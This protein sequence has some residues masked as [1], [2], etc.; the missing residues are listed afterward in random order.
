MNYNASSKPRRVMEPLPVRTVT[1]RIRPDVLCGAVMDALTTSVERVGGE[2]TK[3]QGGHLRAVLPGKKMRAWMPGEW[4]R[5][6]IDENNVDNAGDNVTPQTSPRC[7]QN[8]DAS[9]VASG[10][11][12]MLSLSPILGGTPR[13]SKRKGP[14]YDILPPYIVD[15]QLVTKKVGKE[16]QRMVLIRIYRVQ[17]V[18]RAA[19]MGGEEENNDE[20]AYDV[21][22]PLD[23][24]GGN[25]LHDEQFNHGSVNHQNNPAVAPIDPL[26][27][28]KRSLKALQEASALVQRI[29]AVGGSGFAIDPPPLPMLHSD[30]GDTASVTSRTS[31][32]SYLKSFADTITSPIRYFGGSNNAVSPMK[33]SSLSPC[34]TVMELMSTE[35]LRK[36]ISSPSVGTTS[37]SALAAAK[38]K[39]HGIFP[40]LSMEDAPYV[41]SSWIF[42]RDCIEELDRRCLAYSTLGIYPIFQF[43]ALP[44]LDVHFIA[45]IKAFCRESMIVS[46][47]KTA[48]ELEIY[49]REFEVSCGNVEQL[50]RP[51]F[52]RYKLAP[53]QLPT[54]VPL[55]A[56]PLDFR[57]PEEISP[58]WGPEVMAAL[59][60]ISNDLVIQSTD[61]NDQQAHHRKK[62]S[63]DQTQNPLSSFERSEK[64]ISIVVAAFQQ[65]NDVEQGARLGRKNMQVMDR[66]AKMQAHKRNSIAKIRGSYGT[67]LLATRAADEFHSLRQKS[68]N[69]GSLTDVINAVPDEVPLLTCNVLV[70][71]AGGTCY[72]SHLHILFNTQL[73]P[74]LGGSKIHL[75]SIMNV[76]VTINAPSKSVLSPLPASISLTTAVFGRKSRGTR[77]EVYN[78]IPSIG[79]RRFAKFLEVLRD[80]AM[81]DPNSLK[82]SEKGGLIY[83]AD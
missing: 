10:I 11:S 14:K 65:Q 32:K 6:N 21:I 20:E 78:F 57:V 72:V 16:C 17:D 25:A 50:L 37:K 31:T 83:L 46:L 8:D 44:T 54:P 51:T 12:N 79:A 68:S 4:Q 3:R 77:E 48:S 15:A 27:E 66:L 56:Y 36:H 49:A 71:N 62:N 29:K 41:K 26:L 81:E 22:A 80:V 33:T 74:I 63:N 1:V 43:P 19:L 82:F 39:S 60:K 9:S 73:V 38:Q 35:L 34:P 40:A 52:E 28:S 61:N 47:V 58:P 24:G 13:S 55:T 59:E 45:Q 2:M 75:F 70:G 69:V 42:L 67:N 5:E 76:E 30:A 53:P 23:I 18:A 7:S 64:A